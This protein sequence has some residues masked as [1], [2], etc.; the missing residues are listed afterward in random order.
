MSEMWLV[1]EDDK[2]KLCYPKA[3]FEEVW[4]WGNETYLNVYY[5]LYLTGERQCTAI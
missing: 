5:Q 3:T 4:I 2:F 1:E